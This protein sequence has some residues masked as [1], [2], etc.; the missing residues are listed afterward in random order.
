MGWLKQLLAGKD[1]LFVDLLVQQAR[2]GVQGIEAL[3]CYMATGKA[4]EAEKVSKAEKEADEVRRILVDEINRS[5]VTPF[6]REDM[7]RLSRAID[8]VIDYANT[9]VQEMHILRVEPCEPLL[10]LTELLLLAAQEILLATER[11]QD[12]PNVANDHAR[13]VKKAENNIETTYRQA[14]AAL[15]EKAKSVEDVVGMLK[16]REICRHLANAGDRAD[17]AAN[18][19]ADIVV[20]LT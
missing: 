20:K 5:F 7:Y 11:I 16:L 13:R 2:I 9:T 4:E 12:H 10:K 3:K 8:D 19:I 14:V 15:F 17:E 18:I 1:K 6:D